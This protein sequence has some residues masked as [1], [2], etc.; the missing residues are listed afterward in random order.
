MVP[1]TEELVIRETGEVV[2]LE[3][4]RSCAQALHGIRNLEQNLREAKAILT[5]ALI[6][7]SARVGTKTLHAGNL[8]AIV[9]SNTET[10]WDIE[11]LETLRDLGLPEE[12]YNK[13]V[14]PE[15][16]Y[17]VDGR[18]AKQ[19]AGA[20]PEYARVIEAAKT[21]VPGSSYVSLR[22]SAG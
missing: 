13:L 22:S 4:A 3:D 8:T 7:E 18:V 17:K 14:K 16:S 12:T 15:I 11:T 19:I 9:S 5:D 20:N 10:V 2:D 1:V 6:A 21:V